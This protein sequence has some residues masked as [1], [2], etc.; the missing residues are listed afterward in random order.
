MKKIGIVTI[1]ISNTFNYG[2]KLQAYA[3]Q[4]FLRENGYVAETIRY[5]PPYWFQ[6]SSG[7]EQN[8]GRR[9][10]K[11]AE[12]SF[13]QS[14][15]DALRIVK[16][17]LCRKRLKSL[18]DTR[19]KK[20]KRFERENIA[21]SHKVYDSNSDL[22]ELTERF[23]VWVTGSDQ[24]WNPYY[25]GAYSF[26][27]LDFAPLE[28]RIAYAPSI[29][30][31]SIPEA[32]QQQMEKWL[33]NIDYLSIREVAGKELIK[34][35]FGLEAK[36]VC[37][38]VF[39]LDKKQWSDI[40]IPPV[41][42]QKYF[43]VYILGKKTV[44]IKREVCYL[45][46]KFKLKA[47]DIYSSEEIRSVFAGP[48]EFLGIIENAEFV[49]TDSFHGAAFSVIFERP[50]VTINRDSVHKM[51][52][53]T[54]SLFKQLG[55]DNRAAKTIREVPEVLHIDYSAAKKRLAAFVKESKTFLL[56]AI[57]DAQ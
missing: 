22:T 18:R 30:V 11:L 9:I 4:T 42:K 13:A 49:L 37:D 12:Q 34:N 16:R 19:E 28:K 5:D 7:A 39:L 2:N 31:E 45:E 44:A 25:E 53:R 17:T 52:S 32:I 6:Q 29:A 43:A 51:T 40:A 26:Y 56:E 38:P 20:F 33:R 41:Y 15:D 23:D 46:R 21:Y 24:V 14:L 35:V 47:V 54:E 55:I 1:A 50:V 48:E 8:K 36:L 10:A 57:M 27:Y 3:L